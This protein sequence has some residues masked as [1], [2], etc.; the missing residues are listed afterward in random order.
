MACLLIFQALCA[1]ELGRYVPDQAFARNRTVMSPPIFRD[2]S[3]RLYF[4]RRRNPASPNLTVRGQFAF[5]QTRSFVYRHPNCRGRRNSVFPG[6][7]SR[8]HGGPDQ[9]S[10]TQLLQWSRRTGP[11]ECII[12]VRN[13]RPIHALSPYAHPG[14]MVTVSEMVTR[15]S[16]ITFYEIVTT[17]SN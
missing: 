11:R 15:L 5:A 17:T 3:F 13:Q 9:R 14:D 10:D 1:A 12:D 6:E 8:G 4:S 7:R 16:G 2:G